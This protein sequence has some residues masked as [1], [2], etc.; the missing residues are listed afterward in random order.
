L[1][2]QFRVNARMKLT[3]MSRKTGIPV[4]SIFDKI[5]N[6]DKIGI[7]KKYTI[8][9]DYELIGFEIKAILIIKINKKQKTDL[10]EFLSHHHSV[11]S[12]YRINNGF[13]FILEVIFKNMKIMDDFLEK[14]EKNFDILKLEIHYILEELKREDFNCIDI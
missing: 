2:K 8:L 4:T 11:N 5:T 7:I 9:L 14:I 6:L 3:S 13:D 1:L 10:K 12:L